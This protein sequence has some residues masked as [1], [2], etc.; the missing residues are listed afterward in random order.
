MN[1]TTSITEN[2]YGHAKRLDWIVSHLHKSDKIL[3]FGC[4]TG[5]MITLPLAK[6]G[7]NVTGIDMH[8]E[9]IDYGRTIFAQ[10]GADPKA[11]QAV[12]VAELNVTFDIII[13]SE[14]LEHIPPSD[15]KDVIVSMSS[16]LK[17]DGMLLI[18]VPN[19][20]GW[21]EVES[22]AW[23]KLFIGRCLERTRIVSVI[24]ELKQLVFGKDIEPVHPST[25]SPSPHVQRFTLR[26]IQN[27]LIEHGFDIL[28]IQ[29]SVLFCGQFSNLLFT[30]INPIMKLNT[31]L[32]NKL[33]P[34][35]ASFYIS[36][37][38]K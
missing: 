16:K 11:L 34:I 1:K 28:D 9:S 23:N 10:E 13:A 17:P 38:I 21:F 12:S 14:V 19:G 32:G 27:K 29:G 6:M 25:L 26:S 3:E 37:R 15:L 2:I 36:A 7:Y 33:L 4:G 20:Y 31:W 8:R 5:Y 30:G 22:F 24:N 18:T 35:A